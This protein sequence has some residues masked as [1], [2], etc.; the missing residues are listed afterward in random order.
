MEAIAV[1]AELKTY[2][3]CLLPTPCSLSTKILCPKLYFDCYMFTFSKL[4]AGLTAPLLL[5]SVIIYGCGSQQLMLELSGRW[6][7]AQH[8]ST[9][10]SHDH[11]DITTHNSRLSVVSF[12]ETLPGYA[13]PGDYR[14][15]LTVE[16]VKREGSSILLVMRRDSHVVTEYILTFTRPDRIEGHFRS[17]DTSLGDLGIFP[18]EAGT[19]YDAGKVIMTRESRN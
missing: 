3:C 4:T 10:S 5:T 13:W 12:N 11:W 15:P 1:E 9:R 6:T 17:T 7:V 8:G 18:G 14:R 16:K 2:L 19:I